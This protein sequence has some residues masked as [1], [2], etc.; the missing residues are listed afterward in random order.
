MKAAAFTKALHFHKEN[1]H[2]LDIINVK[3]SAGTL[4]MS[5]HYNIHKYGRVSHNTL[6][7]DMISLLLFSTINFKTLNQHPTGVYLNSSH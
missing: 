2:G 3:V 7:E 6:V 5:V 4:Q 1:V